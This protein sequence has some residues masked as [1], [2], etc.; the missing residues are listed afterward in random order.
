M[1]RIG[2]DLV[3]ADLRDPAEAHHRDA[4]RRELH[5]GQ[6]VRDEKGRAADR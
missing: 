4:V 6:V 2:D 5:D 1:P 3:S